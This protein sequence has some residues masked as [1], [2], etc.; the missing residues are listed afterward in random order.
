MKPAHRNGITCG[1]LAILAAAP[2]VQAAPPSGSGWTQVWGDEFE[3]TS[4]DLPSW[5]RLPSNS[6]PEISRDNVPATG[7]SR[8]IIRLSDSL[9]GSGPETFDRAGWELP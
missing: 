3:G 6:F 7:T 5:T 1:V 9:P 2:V 4:P 8:I